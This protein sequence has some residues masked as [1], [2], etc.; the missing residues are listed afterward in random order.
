MLGKRSFPLECAAAQVC[1]EA[2]ARVSSN[3]FVRDMDLATF[4][5]LD[6]RRL[7]IV[8][9]G[10]ALWQ[11]AQ[12]ANDTT[13]VSPLRRD[14][15]A[16][17]RAADHDGAVLEVARRRKEGTHPEL[18]GESGR[19][20]LVVLAAEVG[21]RW[22][23][24]TAQ[25]ITAL[26]NARAQEVPLVLQ[27]RAQAAWVTRWSASFSC[28]AARAFCVSLLDCRPPGG[29][30]EAIPSVHEVMSERRRSFVS[31]VLKSSHSFI[32]GKK[33]SSLSSNSPGAWIGQARRSA[34]T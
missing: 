33:K 29:T 21:G 24:E 5:A 27:G 12:L 32:S 16:R 17:P 10:L 34:G 15:T 13:M 4:N 28:T 30:G 23:S 18:S 9:D 1:R 8:A 25:F 22:N 2:G 3:M 6:G 7:E 19:A 14:G 26:A 20:R 11:G 31:D